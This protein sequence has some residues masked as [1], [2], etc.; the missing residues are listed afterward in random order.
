MRKELT[1]EEIGDGAPS[2]G[3]VARGGLGLAEAEEL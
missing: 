1:W 2:G 3:D